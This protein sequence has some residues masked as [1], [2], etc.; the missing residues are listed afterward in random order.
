MLLQSCEQKNDIIISVAMLRIDYEG[1]R[2]ST[3]IRRLFRRRRLW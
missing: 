1:G 2:V 3:E